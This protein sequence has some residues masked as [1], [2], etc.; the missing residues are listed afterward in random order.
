MA[1]VGIFDDPD[2]VSVAIFNE[3]SPNKQPFMRPAAESEASAFLARA[4]AA[5]QK[6][7]QHFSQ[8]F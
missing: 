8:G 5:V 2:D 7:E 4:T 3:Y 1:E 6:I